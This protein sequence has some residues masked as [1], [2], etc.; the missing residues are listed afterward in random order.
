VETK[1]G[2]NY[3]V[4][5]FACVSWIHR[6][7]IQ[8]AKCTAK[9]HEMGY[10]ERATFVPW[11][12]TQYIYGCL[13]IEGCMEGDGKLYWEPLETIA[14]YNELLAREKLP[15]INKPPVQF[16]PSQPILPVLPLSQP[17]LPIEIPASQPILPVLPPSQPILPVEFPASQLVQQ[18]RDMLLSCGYCP[19]HPE[20]LSSCMQFHELLDDAEGSVLR[21]S[22]EIY[23]AVLRGENHLECHQVKVDVRAI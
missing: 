15:H 3:H 17:I 4:V 19:T 16:S 21:I 6:C 10:F 7:R 11:D 23:T 12:R 18:A 2:K 14:A 9:N 13:Q 8:A 20:H 5:K 1:E 22:K